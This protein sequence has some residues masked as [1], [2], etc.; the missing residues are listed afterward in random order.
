MEGRFLLVKSAKV[1]IFNALIEKCPLV[2]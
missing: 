1:H 2:Q